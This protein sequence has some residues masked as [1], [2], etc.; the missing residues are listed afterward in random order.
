[1]QTTNQR[2][3]NVMAFGIIIALALCC[4]CT[5]VAL[6]ATS[7]L[8]ERIAH[9][10]SLTP[11][12]DGSLTATEITCSRLVI[13]GAAPNAGQIVLD[14]NGS[15]AAINITS[16]DGTAILLSSNDEVRGALIHLSRDHR[17]QLAIT[18]NSALSAIAMDNEDERTKLVISHMSG[19][20]ATIGMCGKSKG[21]DIL[22]PTGPARRPNIFV[23][24][25]SEPSLFDQPEPFSDTTRN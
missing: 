10:E 18:A 15:R 17:K 4:T 23:R 5:V 11:P 25:T 16:G 1:M 9:L 2:R 12:E 7:D 3:G 24:K 8:R 22:L 19:T 21:P 14:T 20:G 6:N 13:Q